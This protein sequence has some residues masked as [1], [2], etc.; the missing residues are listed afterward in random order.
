MADAY[1][2]LSL[3]LMRNDI[4]GQGKGKEDTEGINTTAGGAIMHQKCP[5]KQ[6]KKFY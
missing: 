2:T 6:F 3:V 5:E 1:G 4:T